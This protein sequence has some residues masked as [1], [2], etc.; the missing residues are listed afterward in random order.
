M[1]ITP[2]F[3]DWNQPRLIEMAALHAQLRDRLNN[4][5]VEFDSELWARLKPFGLQPVISRAGVLASLD[6]LQTALQGLATQTL[7]D[8]LDLKAVLEPHDTPLLLSATRKTYPASHKSL[9]EYL[10]QDLIESFDATARHGYPLLVIAYLL[11]T[12][13]AKAL[14]QEL[15]GAMDWYGQFPGQSPAYL[16]TVKLILKA[17]AIDLDPQ[18]N[19]LGFD[20]EQSALRGLSM[21]GV[22]TAIS[23]HLRDSRPAHSNASWPLASYLLTPHLPIEFQV[24]DIPSEMAW[25]RSNTW[26]HFNQGI[27]LAE[28]IDPGSAAELSFV[29]LCGYASRLISEAG[30]DSE[31]V[32]GLCAISLTPSLVQW[33]ISHRWIDDKALNTVTADEVTLL[34]EH[35]QQEEES[36]GLAAEQLRAP[37]PDRLAMAR[38]VLKSRD[39]AENT[40]F[41]NASELPARPH[42]PVLWE[43]PSAENGLS[44]APAL[45]VVAESQALGPTPEYIPAYVRGRNNEYFPPFLNVSNLPDILG[46]F[47]EQLE[48][49]LKQTQAACHDMLVA[50]LR[51]LPQEERQRL[52]QGTLRIHRVRQ[53]D[54]SDWE[55][56]FG[57]VGLLYREY[58]D[59][60]APITGHC[61]FVLESRYA[62]RNYY[63]EVLPY[64]G[65]F[66]LREELTELP[67][68]DPLDRVDVNAQFTFP[69]DA[70]AYLD[71]TPPRNTKSD[72]V[73][74]DPCWG[75]TEAGEGFETLTGTLARQMSEQMFSEV[76]I[77]QLTKQQR[78]LTWFDR[79]ST[80]KTVAKF[81]IPLWGPI[82]DFQEGVATG[83]RSKLFWAFIGVPLDTVS[84]VMPAIKL[85]ALTLRTA[86][87]GTRLGIQAS[88][89]LLRQL[90]W[91]YS[92]TL[93][94]TIN[95]LG[96]L[97]IIGRMGK[98]GLRHVG[99]AIMR[100]IAGMR[101]KSGRAY[102]TG[103]LA[104]RSSQPFKRAHAA[105]RL[106]KLDDGSQLILHNG[107]SQG[108][109]N[110]LFL[111]DPKS[112]QPAGRALRRINDRG[113]LTRQTATDLILEPDDLGGW[114]LRDP[115]PGL[116]KRWVS[117]GDDL[118]LEADNLIYLK[119]TLADGRVILRPD[120][121][122]RLRNGTGHLVSGACRNRRVVGLAQ[123]APRTVRNLDHSGALAAHEAGSAPVSWFT[124]RTLTASAADMLVHNEH[125]LRLVNG[126]LEWVSKLLRK[127]YRASINARVLGGN[128]RFKQIEISGGIVDGIA[129]QR[130]ISAVVATRK[131]DGVQML[132]TRADDRAYYKGV[133][134]EGQQDIALTRITADPPSDFSA[135]EALSE[136]DA[137]HYIYNGSFD[138]NHYF[139][140]NRLSEAQPNLEAL[141]RALTADDRKWMAR[142]MGGPF[143]LGTSPE[144]AALFCRFTQNK[145]VLRARGPATSWSAITSSTDEALRSRIA[146]D[147]NALHGGATTFNTSNLADPR[148]TELMA[149]G[150]KNLAYARV[151][152]KDPGTPDSLFYSLSGIR[153]KQRLSPSSPD[154]TR[155]IDSQFSRPTN[156]ANAGADELLYLPDLAQ[157]RILEGPATQRRM[158]DS[159]RMILTTMRQHIP[160]FSKV[161]S[162]LVF[163]M[164][165]TCQSCTVGL[166]SLRPQLAPGKFRV[167]EGAVRA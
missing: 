87:V 149:G 144:E 100:V 49:W 159:E 91:T 73:I 95:P 154:N 101:R 48:Q 75:P 113:S 122:L 151:T 14:G 136:N 21:R 126:N 31:Q 7:S 134:T 24:H 139:R 16:L 81:L 33:G 105:Q 69:L 82:E 27:A 96:I 19:A 79:D 38:E 10:G 142:Y 148:T 32:L 114:V 132:I 86:A 66:R 80:A 145:L 84:L 65:V 133:Y 153:G 165:P 94:A 2:T 60:Y 110:Q 62:G 120:R 39:I 71:G 44:N 29:S 128:S 36:M 157:S 152:Y 67:L 162:V 131:S 6:A 26:V 13:E 111:I 17:L 125:R 140:S 166:A 129:D 64:A 51:D 97:Q 4:D 78:G 53:F 93:A 118:Y 46:L 103:P 41:I 116:T 107:K 130:R 74:L 137:L 37:A 43:W 23:D 167:V 115:T 8:S 117:W 88:M 42:E 22:R 106:R 68:Y 127:E 150:G 124:D 57:F 70:R 102:Q 61:G 76:R 160:D 104:W 12:P 77:A 11:E 15:L 164:K 90:A 59:R 99:R 3:T 5:P 161:D 98:A 55:L 89:P 35:F 63:Y 72:R 108:R 163:S 135:T 50:L 138:A 85:G 141:G 9:L 54:F 1:H 158:L 20:F 52:E 45:A 112:L 28:A 156:A 155:F 92:K 119:T 83:D 58:V 143:D 40:R 34:F 123:C 147:L 121:S 18:E 47:T 25:R 146:T 30:A 109:A 56:L